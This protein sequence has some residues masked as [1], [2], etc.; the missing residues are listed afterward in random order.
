[1]AASA[2]RLADVGTELAG[3]REQLVTTPPVTRRA[4]IVAHLA[5]HADLTA[6]ELARAIGSRSPAS[7]YKLLRSMERRA[8]VICRW[9]WRP[10][11]GRDVA[12]WRAAPPGTQSP[13]APVLPPE[14]IARRRAAW[15]ADQRLRR[16]RVTARVRVRPLP[17]L[18]DCGPATAA[19]FFGAEDEAPGAR[20]ERE[21]LAITICRTC[22]ARLAC[23]EYAE[24]TG[25]VSGVWGGQV[26]EPSPA[27]GR[28]T[29]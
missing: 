17:P 16:A 29:P 6:F 21:A 1:M 12:L 4:R 7:L 2:R 11:M 3:I 23:L 28:E 14:V 15:R 13:P 5:G 8:E 10:A 22:P 18:G 19:L 24:A 9:E 27:K 20:A 26:F 25:Q